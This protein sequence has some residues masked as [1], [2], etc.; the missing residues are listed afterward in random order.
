LW[1]RIITD[2]ELKIIAGI[3]RPGDKVSSIVAIARYYSVGKSTA[4]KVLEHLHGEGIL[5]RQ[6]GVGYYVSA[7]EGTA[8]RLKEKHIAV[9]CGMFKECAGYADKLGIKLQLP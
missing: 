3:F 1:N 9:C 4:Q 2:I 8:E 5:T 6:R 7:D